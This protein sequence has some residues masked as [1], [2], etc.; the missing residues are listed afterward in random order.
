MAGADII[1][2]I[3][4][5][6]KP[7]L[8]GTTIELVEVR[9]LV[10]RGRRILRLSIDKPGGV[11]L[12]DCSTVSR[13]VSALLDVH[14]FIKKRYTLEVSS[15]GMDRPLREPADF[16]RNLGRL[17][18]V[19]VRTPSGAS[20]TLVGELSC[21][22]DGIITLKVDGGQKSIPVGEIIKAQLRPKF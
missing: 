2:R 13:E 21:Y 14:D 7:A 12:H 19:A 5:V 4:E 10:E 22:G 9:F 20:Q 6:V 8:E 16:Q 3:K 11:D 17:L 1:H 15:P 18:T